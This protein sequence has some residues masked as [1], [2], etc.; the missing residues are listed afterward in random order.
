MTINKKALKYYSTQSISEQDKECVLDALESP[1]LSRGPKIK[2]FENKLGSKCKNNHVIALNSAT[3]AL[4][5]AYQLNS[6]ESGSIVWTS[7][8]TFVATA[9]AALNLGAKIDFVDISSETLNICPVKL[10]KKLKISKAINKAPDLV[11]L[12][13]FGGNPCE[14]DKIYKLSLKYGFNIVED[15]SHALGASFRKERIGNCTFSNAAVFSFH[16]VKMITTGEGGAL[17]VKTE[18]DY[19]R[20]VTLRSHGIPE[21][22]SN[23]M[24]RGMPEW[25]YEQISLGYN[26]RLSDLQ[27]A[28]GLS[29]LERLNSFVEIRNELALEYHKLLKGGPLKLQKVTDEC[30]SS[31]HLFV[32]QIQ[33]ESISR[34]KLYEYLKSNDIGC[35]VHYIP[36]HLHPF[37]KSKGFKENDFPN[38]ENYF[39]KCLSVPLHQGLSKDDIRFV[40]SKI[41]DFII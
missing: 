27:A 31:Y 3:S 10:E 26:Y 32:L 14:M 23:L 40:C 30:I 15:A 25:Y 37:F 17:I 33:D 4:Q 7:P 38:A 21:D 12:V 24:E 34:D 36:V 22:R 41:E 20:A 18:N 35:Q 9:N 2:E 8:L 1:S 28:L 29:Q 19:K 5:I 39:K 6:I 11:V 16:P 13:H